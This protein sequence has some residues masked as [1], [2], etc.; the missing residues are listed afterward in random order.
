MGIFSSKPKQTATI[1]AA[2]TSSQSLNGLGSPHSTATEKH[3]TLETI[4]IE[5]TVAP[6]TS[7]SASESLFD[8]GKMVMVKWKENDEYYPAKILSQKRQRN[9]DLKYEVTFYDGV[10]DTVKCDDVREVE[11]D[12]MS[13]V[14]KKFENALKKDKETFKKIKKAVTEPKRQLK[15]LKEKSLKSKS[16]ETKAKSSKK[17][18]DTNKKATKKQTSKK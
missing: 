4:H 8:V 1:I 9:N 15:R 14:T 16:V 6:S 7:S 5:T 18:N 11:E 3:E 12:E 13:L 17:T 2:T 10:K